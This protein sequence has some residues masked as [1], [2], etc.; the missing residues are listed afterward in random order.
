MSFA[1]TTVK[2][3]LQGAPEALVMQ[4]NRLEDALKSHFSPYVSIESCKITTRNIFKDEKAAEL[5]GNQ[6]PHCPELNT[7][8]NI[9]CICLA[10][11]RS[12]SDAS[13]S[14]R[15]IASPTEGHGSDKS[16]EWIG[17]EGDEAP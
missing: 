8:G 2:L 15:A 1:V 17:D 7:P 14:E 5:P 13:E 6:I 16:R 9:G 10:C 11:I 12:R 4:I 3:E